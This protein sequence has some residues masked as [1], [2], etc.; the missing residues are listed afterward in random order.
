MLVFVWL[1]FFW[2]EG[3]WEGEGVWEEVVLFV[4]CFDLFIFSLQTHVCLCFVSLFG[5]FILVFFCFGLSKWMNCV[6]PLYKS[7]RAECCGEAATS[8]TADR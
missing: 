2:G 6:F 3:I 7:G 4:Y 1:G 5:F 8:R